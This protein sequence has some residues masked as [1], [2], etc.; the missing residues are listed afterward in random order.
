M[1]WLLEQPWKLVSVHATHEAVSVEVLPVHCPTRMWRDLH[2]VKL[3]GAHFVVS[4]LDVPSQ[5]PTCH[6]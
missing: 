1:Y 6:G 2:E 5:K 3:H 4:V